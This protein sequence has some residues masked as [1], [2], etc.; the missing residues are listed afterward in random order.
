LRDLPRGTLYGEEKSPEICVGASAGGLEAFTELI[1]HLP[2]D[3]GI[4]VDLYCSN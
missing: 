4:R 1:K 2:L 3:T